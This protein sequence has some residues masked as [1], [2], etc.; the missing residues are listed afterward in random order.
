MRRRPPRSKRTD[1]LVPDTTLFRSTVG[2]E[3]S[4]WSPL[5]RHWLLWMRRECPDIAVSAQIDASERLMER[6][7][8]G[9]LDIA[10]LYVAPSRPGVLALLLFEDKLV[11][12]RTTPTNPTLAPDNPVPIDWKRDA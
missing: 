2:A 8:D 9:S 12:G 10:V 1:T 5:L 11:L 3:L 6:V 4:L 7:Q